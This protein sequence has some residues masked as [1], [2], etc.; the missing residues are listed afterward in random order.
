MKTNNFEET[1][2]LG[3]NFARSLLARP[4]RGPLII[5][6]YGDLGSGKT[7][8][9]QGIAKGLGIKKRIISPTFIMVRSYKLGVVS[10]YHIDLY[11]VES[12][13]DIE[14]LGIEEIINNRNNIVVIEW[15]EKMGRLLPKNRIDVRF[16][17]VAENR[18]L[19]IIK[20]Y[21]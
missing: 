3:E 19:I 20:R 8:F 16:E 15:A 14:G 13:K 6:L 7:T 21:E 2:K 10:F 5:A 12:E 4:Q 17:Y 11:R 9:V 18:R 1:Q